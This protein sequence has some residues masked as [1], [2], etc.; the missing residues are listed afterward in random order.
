MISTKRYPRCYDAT[1]LH[2]IKPC[3]HKP[4][5]MLAYAAARH[6]CTTYSFYLSAAGWLH[7]TSKPFFFNIVITYHPFIQ[8]LVL[9]N[10]HTISSYLLSGSWCILLFSWTLM[11]SCFHPVVSELVSG[12][13]FGTDCHFETWSE[14]NLISYF[15]TPSLTKIL[16]LKNRILWGKNF[17]FLIF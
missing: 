8:N 11:F 16:P 10:H 2:C 7:G 12:K 17:S 4:Q 9:K 5:V 13:R 6:V 15:F 1:R 3:R 14:K